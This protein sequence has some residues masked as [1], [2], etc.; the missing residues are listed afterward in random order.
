[1]RITNPTRKNIQKLAILTTTL[2]AATLSPVACQCEDPEIV[3]PECKYEVEP[4]GQGNPVVFGEVAVGEERARSI[5]IRN[6]GNVALRDFEFAIDERNSVHYTVDVDDDL[7]IAAEDDETIALL[8]EPKSSSSN[9]NATMTIQTNRSGTISCPVVQVFLEGSSF[10][11]PEEDAGEPDAGEPD[12][13]PDFDGGV[14]VLPDGGVLAGPD[15]EFV[16]HGALQ[17]AR[18]GF[19]SVDLGEGKVAVI[20]GY[21]E[22]GQALTSIEIV[23]AQT[24]KSSIVADMV[25]P[26]AEPS[27]I[28]LLDGKIAIVGGRNEAVGGI[29]L[30]TVEIFDPAVNTL[31]CPPPQ[32]AC[33]LDDIDAGKGI[34]PVGRI[35][36]LLALAPSGVDR[37]LA[38]VG[39]RT[40]EDGEEVPVGGG[41]VLRV[42]AALQRSDLGGANLLEPLL[43][44]QMAVNS[45][46][47]FVIAGGM[48]LDGLLR[49]EVLVYSRA[50]SSLAVASNPLVAPRAFG[51]MQFTSDGNL[52]VTGGL[53]ADL[54]PYTDVE[55]ITAPFATAT[56]ELLDGV[57][58]AVRI[59]PQLTVLNSDVLVLSGGFAA[60]PDPLNP[61]VVPQNDADLLI[62]FGDGY[63][64]AAPQNQL[65][66]ARTDAAVLRLD[67]PVPV[68]PAAPAGAGVGV[69]GVEEPE[70]TEQVLFIGGSTTFPRRT[71]QPS[72]ERYSLDTNAFQIYGLLGEG[73][74]LAAVALPPA[75]ALLSTGGI[76]GNTG[77]ITDR[78]V[79]FDTQNQIYVEVAPI[80]L[81]RNEHSMTVLDDNQ[82]IL[83]AGGKGNA[84][85]VLDSA[86][87]YNPFLGIDIELPV[88]LVRA[89]AQHTAT[90]LGDGT[91][92]LCGGIGA[93]GEAIDTCERFTPPPNLFNA[94]TYD[95]ARFVQ[96]TGRL[97]A[98]RVDHVALTL[99]NGDVLLLGG[100]DVERDLGPADR[101]SAGQA[102]LRSSG[103]PVRA[104][105]GHAT[106]FLDN[107]KI[108]VAGGDVF[109]GALGPSDEAEL[110]DETLDLFT[111]VVDRLGR[112]RTGGGFV[113]LADG[114][115]LL[116]GG[117]KLGEGNFP[118]VSLAVTEI[119]N[120]TENAFDAIDLPLTFGRSDIRI[121]DTFGN[122]IVAGGNRR[123]GLLRTGFELRTPHFFVETLEPIE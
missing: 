2:T 21:G 66:I 20:G 93:G 61:V 46:G 65:A 34:L 71:P 44:A 26:R 11:R 101:Y 15:A 7:V 98:G 78:A 42:G 121:V 63:L 113:P 37:V 112:P 86:S 102:A 103:T 9:L 81:P 4:A 49:D 25:L 96:V 38:V 94:N 74:A 110:Y 97:N 64:R 99:S 22:N 40:L 31:S 57:T 54:T 36:P 3:T 8:F 68:V 16:A 85:Q 6:T 111:S 30:S 91:V 79:A 115:W 13:G 1:M 83:I 72:L 14:I 114:S 116:V 28:K 104:R 32:G 87:I 39:G 29:A 90:L 27:A 5:R 33:N 58:T 108:L 77:R 48:G 67:V 18:S 100:G 47:T 50:T 122:F 82:S 119:Y 53:Q 95:D 70:T 92:L 19:A 56:V 51:A 41:D 73:A 55:K 60:L 35:A 120:P 62:P 107:G 106:A 43:G 75:G 123:D 118:T 12:G 89:R 80:A 105:R 88:K 17:R 24:G 117:S 59:Q 69:A 109:L 23:D 76:D 84:G 10:E 45:D 52:I